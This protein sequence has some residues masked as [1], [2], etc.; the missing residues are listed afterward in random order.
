MVIPCKGKNKDGSPCKN[1]TNDPSEY[2]FRHPVERAAWQSQQANSVE[3]Q[4]TE[5][6]QTQLE[7]DQ[8]TEVQ[9]TETETVPA[10]ASLGTIASIR[11][12]L[13][14]RKN[15][16]RQ[17]L[18]DN[19]VIDQPQNHNAWWKVALVVLAAI[20]VLGMTAAIII[21]AINGGADVDVQQEQE[22]TQTQEITPPAEQPQPQISVNN[23]GGGRSTAP[24]SVP[25]NNGPVA[26][27]PAP[28]VQPEPEPTTQPN[29]GAIED[30]TGSTYITP[31]G[32]FFGPIPEE[33]QPSVGP[34]PT[35][36]P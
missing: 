22:Q 29:Q 13:R 28:V 23:R 4:Q 35:F 19:P 32:Y 36:T 25:I 33:H 20:L 1:K 6:N 10:Q 27:E 24:V 9:Q 2:C 3:V 14:E 21:L 30:Q 8:V 17:A 26:T 15:A 16:R 5:V 18:A 11:L 31:D 34:Q 12:L 7:P